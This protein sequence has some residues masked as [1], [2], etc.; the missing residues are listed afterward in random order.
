MRNK[1]ELFRLPGGTVAY[2]EINSIDQIIKDKGL[3]P[4]GDAQKFH[5]ANV[6]RRIQKYMAFRT[7]MTIKVMITQT[8]IN[9]P[10]LLLDVPY[11]QVLLNGVSRTG[12]PLVYTKTKNPQAGPHWDKRLVAAE[13]PQMQS[14]LQ[15]FIERGG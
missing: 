4:G 13:M 6:L 9:K 11:G 8:D 2:L 15:A 1:T 10:F 3:D 12:K 14:E 5:T 7:G